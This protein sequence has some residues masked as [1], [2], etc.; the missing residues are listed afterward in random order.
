MPPP[1]PLSIWAAVVAAV[2][3]IS[4]VDRFGDSKCESRTFAPTDTPRSPELTDF[5][6]VHGHGSAASD[7][8]TRRLKKGKGIS[9]G[10]IT[11]RRDPELI[12]VLC[13][14][15]VRDVSHKPGGRLPLLLRGPQLPSQPLRRLRRKLQTTMWH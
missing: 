10:P 15:P 7:P 14:Q 13:S 3:H 2:K 4:G 8:L 12:P 9:L 11:E 5:E 1:T 6:L